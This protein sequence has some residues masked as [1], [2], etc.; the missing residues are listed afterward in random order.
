MV[1]EGASV[2]VV[3]TPLFGGSDW[4]PL[5]EVVV[6]VTGV[7]VVGAVSVVNVT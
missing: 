4:F 5:V 7:I 2:V 3:V 6:D 1:V